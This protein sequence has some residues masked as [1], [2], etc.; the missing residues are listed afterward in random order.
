MSHDIR[1]PMNAIINLTHLVQQEK[2]FS[3]VQAYLEKISVSGNFLLGLINDILDMSKIESGELTLNKER[4]SKKEFSTTI[5]TVISPLMDAKHLHFHVSLE[6]GGF[7]ILTDKVRFN[8]IFFNLLSNAAKFTPEGGDVWF[9][10]SCHKLDPSS[11]RRAAMFGLNRPA[12]SWI[13]AN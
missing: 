11:R 6:S 13:T 7:V 9:E 3:T 12:I 10:S 8:Q 2:D 5:G 1:T 4:Y